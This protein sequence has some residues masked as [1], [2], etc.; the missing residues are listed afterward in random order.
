MA[1]IGVASMLVTRV[2]SAEV[3]SR[4]TDRTGPSALFGGNE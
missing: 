3:E 2:P 4:I 1:S